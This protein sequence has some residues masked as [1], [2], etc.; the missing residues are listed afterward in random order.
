MPDKAHSDF[1]ACPNCDGR[2][3]VAS[4]LPFGTK[5]C[6]QCGG[7]GAVT[8]IRQQLLGKVESQDAGAGLVRAISQ[9]RK[10]PDGIGCLSTSGYQGGTRP[11][12]SAFLASR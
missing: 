2:G 4:R 3:T 10:A 11:S 6:D 7:R 12:S 5:P 1:H 8:P 9:N